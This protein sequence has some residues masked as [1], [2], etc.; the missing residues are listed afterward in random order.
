MKSLLRPE[1]KKTY[2]EVA[3][4]L[5]EQIM[6]GAYQ[7]GDRLPS[8]R[9]LSEQ[10]G[11]GQSTVREAIGSLKTIGLV[12]IRHG[13]GTFVAPFNRQEILSLFDSIR[14][15]SNEDISYLLELRKIIET[16]TVR[17]AAER[18]GEADLQAMKEALQAME[19]SLRENKFDHAADWK[20]H[21]AIAQASLNPFLESVLRSMSKTMEV[22]IKAGLEKLYNTK[23]NPKRYYEQHIDIY[24]AIA[25]RNS[26]QAEEAMIYHLLDAEKGIFKPNL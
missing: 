2:E 5:R 17:L 14:P 16:G 7:A 12:N 25:A 6:T 11:V 19:H 23:D 26:K 24:E 4:H 20:F 1:V 13:E 15:I 10:F 18:R 3:D 8:I 21:Y 22:I 9:E